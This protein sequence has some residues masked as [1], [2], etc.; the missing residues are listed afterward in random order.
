MIYCIFN[1]LITHDVS[2]TTRRIRIFYYFTNHY[3]TE[4][5]IY[6]LGFFLPIFPNPFSSIIVCIRY[7]VWCFKLFFLLFFNNT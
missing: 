2:F 7:I 5:T 1:W 3:F 4:Y 6:F